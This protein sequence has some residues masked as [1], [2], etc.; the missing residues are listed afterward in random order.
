MNVEL[1]T[2][3]KDGKYR[4]GALELLSNGSR[5]PSE[6]ASKLDVNRASI[7]RIIGDLKE[8][9][10]IQEI[11]AGGRTKSIIITKKGKEMVSAVRNGI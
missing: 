5:L 4:I 2:W 10:L 9:G 1:I 7:S 6:L 3:L 11:S 8:K